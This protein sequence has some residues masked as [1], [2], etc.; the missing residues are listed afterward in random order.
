MS[1]I[2]ESYIYSFVS[3]Q[4]SSAHVLIF[5][6][7]NNLTEPRWFEVDERS[8]GTQRQGCNQKFEKEG[9]FLVLNSSAAQQ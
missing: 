5:Q 4:I 1:A 6:E 8:S 2:D 7:P 9:R 3:V